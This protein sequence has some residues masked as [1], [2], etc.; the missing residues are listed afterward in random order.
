[1]SHWRHT[2]VDGAEFWISRQW[3]AFLSSFSHWQVIQNPAP[4]TIVWRQCDIRITTKLLSQKR[5][6]LAI[7]CI[8]LHWQ[9]G[10]TQKKEEIT[11]SKSLSSIILHGSHCNR[12][13]WL[14]PNWL[15]S[16][17]LSL[18][19]LSLTLLDSAWHTL[20]SDQLILPRL[21]FN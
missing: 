9:R 2:M 14:R 8:S 4:S 16:G 17:W 21:G 20:G 18:D 13:L 19:W 1:M 7:F 12:M 3:L 10:T 15:G 11:V 5:H 6:H